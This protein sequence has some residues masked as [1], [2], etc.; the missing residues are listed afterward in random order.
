M[1][2]Q[3]IMNFNFYFAAH[4][5]NTICLSRTF[6][7]PMCMPLP[8]LAMNEREMKELFLSILFPP[9]MLSLALASLSK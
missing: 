7:S 1:V 5:E 3:T 8:P 9:S 2:G 4:A 6:L